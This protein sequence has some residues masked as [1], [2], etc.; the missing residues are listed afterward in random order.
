MNI[1]MILMAAIGLLV[2]IGIGFFLGRSSLAKATEQRA[3]IESELWQT[4]REVEEYRHQVNNHFEKTAELLGNLTNSY[5]E[6]T[7]RYKAVYEH[8]AHGAQTLASREVGKKLAASTIDQ[9]IYE[10]NEDMHVAERS[11]KLPP[12]QT[13]VKKETPPPPSLSEPGKTV[14]TEPAAEKEKKSPAENRKTTKKGGTGKKEAEAKGSENSRETKENESPQR[15]K[16]DVGKATATPA[17]KK[18]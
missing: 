7:Q 17:D 14:K 4:K 15:D 3:E 6:M 1:E 18:A 8:L 16:G 10:A 2:G 13:P 12:A 9:L 11:T 5:K